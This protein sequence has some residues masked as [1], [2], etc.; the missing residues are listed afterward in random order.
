ME[1]I[2][3]YTSQIDEEGY[4]RIPG[5]FDRDLMRETLELTN[6]YYLETRDQLAE[7]LPR[8][9]KNDPFLWNPQNKDIL[10]LKVMFGSPIV[11]QILMHYLND[12][13]F[14][15]IPQDK[16]NYILRN[17]LARSSSKALPMHIDSMVPYTGEHVFVMQTSIILEDQSAANG[18]TV[19]VPG[20]HRSGEYVDQASFADAIPLVCEAGDVVIWD[21]RIWHGAGENKHGGTRW[22]LI[23]TYAR[24]WLKQMFQIPRTLPQEIYEKLSDKEKAVLGFCSIPYSDETEG[25]DMKRGYDSLAADVAAYR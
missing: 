12:R 19:V 15:Q 18:S 8:L 1:G 6:R 25:V 17:L 20:S 10:F 5:V 21:S 24:W 7:N 9:A 2:A 4:C 23:A 3:S 13:W 16:P 11:E 14:K 22:A